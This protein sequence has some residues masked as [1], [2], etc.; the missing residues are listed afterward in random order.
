M[1]R[2]EKLAATKSADEIIRDAYAVTRGH[3]PAIRLVTWSAR[4]PAW[5]F[6]AVP[7]ERGRYVRTDL[8]VAYVPCPYPGCEAIRGEPCHNGRGLYTAGTH[9]VRRS[10]FNRQRRIKNIEGL[11][12]PRDVE[13]PVKR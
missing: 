11:W 7:N 10:E 3:V 8:A 13:H 9:S 2:S 4:N 1:R 5:I 6:V 12:L